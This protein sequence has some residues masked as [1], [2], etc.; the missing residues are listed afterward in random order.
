MLSILIPVYN[1]NCL[2]LVKSL[3]QQ[4]EKEQIKFE[5]I[6]ID[7]ASTKTIEENDQL[8]RIETVSFIKLQKNIGRSRIRNLLT[9]N[10]NY[11]WL[12]FLDA[13]TLPKQV[14]FIHKYVKIILS[15]PKEQVF[16]GG[17]AYRRED[18]S[19]NNQL[20]YKYGKSRESNSANKR[21]KN[22]YTALLMS[23]TLIKKS[24]FDKVKFN[25]NITLYGHEDALFSYN[26]H[27]ASIPIK[28]VDNPIYHTGLE[29]DEVF[30][31][32]SKIAVKNLFGLHAQGLMQPEI[33]KLLKWYVRIKAFY[34]VPLF[35]FFYT[36]FNTKIEKSLSDKNPSLA[37]FDFYR[38]SYLCYLSKMKN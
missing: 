4:L 11:D 27:A 9:T 5:I 16:F 18:I 28:H 2:P 8:T 34:L 25:N 30:I 20:R 22:P 31:N 17:L 14:D 13:D 7:D 37:L 36:K 12:L 38:L 23:N 24:V 15:K 33:N 26:L 35:S 1:I 19:E 3:V 21:N 10:A 6:C 29:P 32:K